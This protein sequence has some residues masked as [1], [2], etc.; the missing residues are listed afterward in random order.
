MGIE[1]YRLFKKWLNVYEDESAL[2]LWSALLLFIIHVSDSFFTNTAETAFLKRYGVEYLPF[3]YMINA[4]STFFIMGALTAVMAKMPDSRLLSYM[5]VGS[6]ALV[7]TIRLVIPLGFDIIYPIMFLLKSQLEVLL[8]L[9]FWNMAND[10]F[11]TRQSKRIFPLVT[12]GGVIGGILGSFATSPLAKLIHMDNLLLLYF[13]ISLVGAA[14]VRRMGKL[15]PTLLVLESA[16]AKKGEKKGGSRTNIIQ[17]FKKIVPLMKES[18][19]V[20][21]LIAFAL[22]ANIVITIMNYEFNFAVDQSFASEK[23]MIHFFSVFR[24]FLNITSLVIL[25]FVGKLYAKWGLPIALMIHPFNYV[26]AFLAFLFRFDIYSAMYAR[27]STN[28][29]RTTINTPAMAV[30]MGLFHTSQRAIVRPF[31]RGT[32]VRIG[33]LLGSGAILLLGDI[34][35]PRYLSIVALVCMGIW[36]THDFILKKQYPKIL[37]DLISRSMLDLKSLDNKQVIQVFK[38]KKMQAQLLDRFL[39]SRGEDCLWYAELLRGQDLPAFDESLLKVLKREDDRTRIGLLPLLSHETGKSAIPVFRELVDANKPQLLLAMV[40]AANRFHPEASQDFNRDIFESS[41]DP[42][43]RGYSL[44]GLYHGAPK[45]FSGLIQSLLLSKDLKERWAGVIAAGESKNEMFVHTLREMLEVENDHAVLSSILRSLHQLKDPQ[46]NGM[47]TPY[48]SHSSDSI[49]LAALEAFEILDDQGLMKVIAFMG[50]PAPEVSAKAM[51]K[52]QNGTFQNPLVLVESLNIPR[53]KVREN[54]FQ[55]LEKLNIKDLDVYRFARSQVE[56]SYVCFAEVE[57]LR[58]LALSPERDLLMDHLTQ[59]RKIKVE[60]IL[61]VLSIQD[62]SGQMRILWRGL[63]SS[64]ARQRSNSIEA[65]TTMVD[66]TLAKILV[67]L[68]EDIPAEDRLKVGRKNFPLPVFGGSNGAL[69]SHLLTKGEW[70]TS[71]LTLFLMAKQKIDDVAPDLLEGLASSE[72]PYVRQMARQVMFKGD[73]DSS[74]RGVEMDM[75]MSLSER[76]SHLKKIA[77]FEGLYVGELAAIGSI[78]QEISYSAGEVVIKE[79]E[80]GETMYLIIE[81]DVTVSK[82][83][84]GEKGHSVELDRIST[85]DYFGEMA[86]FEEAPRSATIRTDAPSHF[87][88]IHKRE[89][90]GMVLEYPLIALHICKALSRRI[91]RLHEKLKDYEKHRSVQ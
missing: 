14:V 77:I 35:H 3:I 91:R 90:T 63:T 45:E 72:N 47:V 59:E 83:G 43:I 41:Q 84:K 54:I 4:V 40:K 50:D 23:G 38:D 29:L 87:L 19:L 71:L 36:L 86:L 17:E 61:R 85:G 74:D 88:V 18:T 9:V 64:D 68:L 5:F 26:L 62:A 42:E 89:F 70:I 10:L 79:G 69:L 22:M 28:V 2:F 34:F 15:Y 73:S 21:V 80:W 58:E 27:I 37:L 78:A 67:P 66:S 6:G 7:G 52:I 33:T 30:V 49:R 48:F 44:A 56:K 51:E 39:S 55:L 13:I 1:M 12:A 8:A 11:N 82:E 53:R 81:G 16:P 76:I 75:G 25:L 46:L 60:N 32:V 57:A 31:L 65:L 24:G 20:R